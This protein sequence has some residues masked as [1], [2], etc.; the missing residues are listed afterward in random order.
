MNWSA[1]CIGRRGRHFTFKAECGLFK[2][3]L[4]LGQVIYHTVEKRGKYGKSLRNNFREILGAEQGS[5][6]NL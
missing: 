2:T 4:Q 5:E 6:K 1:C 3:L